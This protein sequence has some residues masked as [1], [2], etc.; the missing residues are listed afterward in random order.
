MDD[1]VIDKI[2]RAI[3]ADPLR[4]PDVHHL[5][6]LVRKLI[7]RV[8]SGTRKAYALLNFYCDWTLHSEINRSEPG[9]KI[10]ARLSEIIA[11]HL[12]KTDNSTLIADLS[13]ALSLSGVRN[14]LNGLIARYTGAAD[15]VTTTTWRLMIPILLEIISHTPL[16]IA[17]NNTRLKELARQVRSRPLKGE[18]VI[19]ELAITKVPSIML[20][21]NAPQNEITYCM[22]FTTTDTTKLVVPLTTV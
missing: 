10:L 20:K 22:M 11:D 7:E 18:F 4:E 3:G 9:A 2:R 6:A 8:P 1:E 5:F 17:S 15:T 19:E 16:K 13:R 12:K 14:E 21:D